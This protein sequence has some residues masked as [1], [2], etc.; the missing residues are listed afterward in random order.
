MYVGVALFEI[1]IGHARSLKDKRSVVRS[2]RDGIRSRHR[3]SVA[4][5][6]HQ[7]LHQR[8]RIAVSLV[9]NEQS[10]VDRKLSEISDDIAER[11][12]SELTDWTSE[13]LPFDEHV[14][15]GSGLL[16]ESDQE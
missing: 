15:L 13:I 2:I 14:S 5:V 7:D 16:T 10:V 1:F 6:A 11:G 4:E 12:D 8:S 3:V 9:S